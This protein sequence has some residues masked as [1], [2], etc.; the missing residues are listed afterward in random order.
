LI[1]DAGSRRI[2]LIA[3]APADSKQPVSADAG[4]TAAHVITIAGT[5]M[6]PAQA[7]PKNLA[8]GQAISN[9][10][11]TGYA[12]KLHLRACNGVHFDASSGQIMVADGV[13]VRI[14]AGTNKAQPEPSS[15]CVMGCIS[16]FLTASSVCKQCPAR[17]RKRV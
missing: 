13:A 3:R 4:F 5:G 1:A 15:K 6:L 10:I 11:Q 8:L 9:P 7:D 14:L 2:R 12:L 17:V 16:W